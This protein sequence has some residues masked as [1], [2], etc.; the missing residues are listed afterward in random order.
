LVE[1][2]LQDARFEAWPADLDD[3]IDAASDTING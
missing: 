3:P 2:L 1:S